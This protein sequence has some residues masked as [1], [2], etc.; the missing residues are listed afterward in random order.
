MTIKQ[1]SIFLENK[2]GR[3]AEITAVLAENGI[4][5]RALSIAD[6]ADYGIL[7][8]IVNQPDEAVAAL[9]AD[10]NTVSLTEV[11][12]VSVDDRPGG[13]SKMVSTLC[14]NGVDTEYMYAFLNPEKDFAVVILRVLD[15]DKAAGVL[16]SSG[17]TLLSDEDIRAM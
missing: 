7:R 12:G 14:E 17:F 9:K 3:L 4:D 8:L 5:I 2:S 13:L 10:G 16:E 11:L 15:N 1:L 6:T